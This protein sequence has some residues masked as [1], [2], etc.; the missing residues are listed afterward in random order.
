MNTPAQPKIETKTV[1]HEYTID[2]KI[3]MG[4]ELSRAIANARGV[5]EEFD[6]VKASYKAK[7][8]AAQARIGSI[9][10]SL[11]NGFE[12]KPMKCRVVFRPKDKRKDFY[13]V[14][15]PDDADPVLTEEME[16]SDYEQDLI[17]AESKFEAR[18]EIQLFNPAPGSVGTLVVGR[19]RGRWYSALRITVGH[20]KIEERLD[21]EQKSVRARWDA[22][23]LAGKRAMEWLTD[24]LGKDNAAGFKDPIQTAVEA[25]R[26]REE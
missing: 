17:Q 13:L 10:T 22:V 16:A 18:E 25:H 7:L 3:A 9:S 20:S 24:A 14:D 5:E 11:M 8:T 21:S 2:E 15:A 4:G 12:L 19:F 26:E 6:E 23:R 1:R